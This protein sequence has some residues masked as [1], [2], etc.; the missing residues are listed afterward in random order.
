MISDLLQIAQPDTAVYNEL[1]SDGSAPR[2]YWADFIE[3]LQG[4]GTAELARRWDRAER[5]IRENGVTY[6]VYTDPRGASHPWRI[7][8]IPLLIP[9]EEWRYIEAGI[10]QRGRGLY[11]Q[12]IVLLEL[13]LFEI[14]RD[15]RLPTTKI[16]DKVVLA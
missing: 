9:S 7:D 4:I 3:G 5:R 6:N 14:L 13:T 10:V 2:A 8:T 12:A 1:S 11:I 15:L 16:F